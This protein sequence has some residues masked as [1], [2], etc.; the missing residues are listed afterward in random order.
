MEAYT[1]Q[2]NE[3]QIRSL[4]EA[5]AD[6]VRRKD[7]EGVMANYAPEMVGFDAWGPLRIDVATYRDHWQQ[8]FAG[9]E[10]PLE[11]EHRDVVVTAGEDVAFVHCLINL[12]GTL[13]GG[14]RHSFWG[15]GTIGFRRIDGQWFVTH[16][17]ASA[18]FDPMTG[19]V[20]NEG[21]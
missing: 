3:A 18:P 2:S 20:T 12:R 17:H 14:Q 1:H 19:Q 11:L 21:P 4:M 10:G 13:R 6:A 8:C 15:R 9:H 16:E 7:I 5:W